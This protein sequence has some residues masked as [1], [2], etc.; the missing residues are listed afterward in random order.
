MSSYETLRN[1][2]VAYY[3]AETYFNTLG[4]DI[5]LIKGDYDGLMVEQKISN[6]V[7]YLYKDNKTYRFTFLKGL[8][9]NK[10]DIVDLI[11]T[12]IIE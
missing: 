12:V 6:Y 1:N 5:T 8:N 11:S 9:F 7:V 2:A 4:N 3:G 10:A